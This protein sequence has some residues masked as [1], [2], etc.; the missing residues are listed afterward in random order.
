LA[1]GLVV[2]GGGL[3][4]LASV[5]TWISASVE[6]VGLPT[7]TS[8]VNGRS[9]APLVAACGLLALAGG[10]AALLAGSWARRAIGA[11]LLVVG[12]SA[13]WSVLAVLRT[14]E[15]S[16]AGP[17]GDA[18]GLTSVTV[19]AATTSIWPVVAAVACT[20]V[21]VGG[22]WMLLRAGGWSGSTRRYER[23]APDEPGTRNESAVGTDRASSAGEDPAGGTGLWDALDRGEDPTL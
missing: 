23:G 11:L 19:A 13:A 5:P 8:Q 12:A 22:G 14:P 21:A 16:V 15:A 20:L 10:F 1:L 7:V 17:L 18:V 2:V 6:D 4:L 3:A 9:V